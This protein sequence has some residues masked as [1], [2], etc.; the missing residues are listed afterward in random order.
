MPLRRR[1][2]RGPTSCSFASAARQGFRQRPCGSPQQGLR[3][4]VRARLCVSA[5][6]DLACGGVWHCM[7]P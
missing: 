2:R 3:A 6:G 7:A 1:P 4:R 5:C